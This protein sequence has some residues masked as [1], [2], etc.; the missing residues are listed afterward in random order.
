MGYIQP[1]AREPC[2][3][4]P[5]DEFLDF[6][7]SA[8]I[9]GLISYLWLLYVFWREGLRIWREPR[10]S[11]DRNLTLAVMAAMLAGMIHG[12]IDN[13]YF[14]VDLSLFFW[15]FCAVVSWV[16]ADGLLMPT[17]TAIPRPAPLTEPATSGLA[18][19]GAV[20]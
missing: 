3:S 13:S 4:H 6:W 14:L 1:G 2:L 7:L 19:P 8:G 9:L 5:H 12:L 17:A 15:L 20:E 16:H 10:G 18:A 11:R